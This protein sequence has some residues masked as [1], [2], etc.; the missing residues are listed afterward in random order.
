M[1][2]LLHAAAGALVAV[3]LALSMGTAEAA[4]DS[5]KGKKVFNKCKACHNVDNEKNKV[6]PHLVG[7]FGRTAGAVDGFKYSKAMKGSGIVWDETTIAEYLKAPKTYIKG[8]RMAFAGL[9]KQADVDNVIAYLK[10]S[11]A[12]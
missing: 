12:Q 9:K 7:I 4:G 10:E 3:S 2:I 1:R 11:T 8:N 5:A 6:G